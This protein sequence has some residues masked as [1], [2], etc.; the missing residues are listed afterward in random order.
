MNED[1]NPVTVE[2]AEKAE[3][4][5]T[6]PKERVSPRALAIVI[7]G[8]FIFFGIIFMLIFGVNWGL[9]DKKKERLYTTG[10]YVEGIRIAG[11]AVSGMTLDEADKAVREVASRM[12]KDT[13]VRFRVGETIYRLK[14]SQIGTY[15]EYRSK[16]EAAMLEGRSG[17]IFENIR[18][19][20][21]LRENGLDFP[22]KVELDRSVLESTI[23]DMSTT[24]NTKAHSGYLAP[25]VQRTPSNFRIESSIDAHGS[26]IGRTVDIEKLIED[27]YKA[28]SNGLSERIITS[29]WEETSPE[30][31]EADLF[32]N[33]QIRSE[34]TVSI[35]GLSEGEVANIY[36]AAGMLSGT[37]V[38]AGEKFSFLSVLG[39][40]GPDEGWTYAKAIN[41]GKN[42]QEFGGGITYVSS[43]L[44][45]SI[46]KSDF[47]PD[48]Y[49]NNDFV[50]ANLTPGIE[51]LVSAPRK[52]D[53]T[54]T[55]K[56]S[57]PIYILVDMDMNKTESLTVSIYGEDQEFNIEI[58]SKLIQEKEVT[59]EPEVII[60]NSKDETYEEWTTDRKNGQFVLLYKSYHHKSTGNINGEKTS[61]DQVEYDPVAGVK[62]IGA[63]P[64][65]TDPDSQTEP[66]TDDKPD[67]GG[68]EGGEPTDP[69]NGEGGQGE[70]TGNDDD[71]K[72]E[73]GET[74]PPDQNETAEQ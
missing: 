55:N 26:V 20:K 28:V 29:V 34:Y 65:E 10:T 60:D 18:R 8:V 24:L 68:G 45:G 56:T 13:V 70:G 33:C 27:I 31:T 71:K 11:V 21:E 14:G 1:K 69:E 30:E 3:K 36:K 57:N 32:A 50:P 25:N 17:S 58:E 7:G 53:F 6:R 37:K 62:I 43:A 2:T 40:V 52:I 73:D 59:A 23:K 47:G 12:L 46:L 67:D 66:G 35:S 72:L 4:K 44:Y 9:N 49:T 39:E 51:V 38:E 42:V 48:E 16:L 19:K 63:Q 15:I 61:L 41:T 54:F 22:I 74:T 5:N 64:E